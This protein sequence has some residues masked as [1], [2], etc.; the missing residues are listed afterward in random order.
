MVPSISFFQT[1]SAGT[2]IK[3][4]QQTGQIREFFTGSLLL[5]LMELTAFLM[6]FPVLALFSVELTLLVFV[7]AVLMGINVWITARAHRERL[8]KL[9]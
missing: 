9:Y 5:T 4:M 2:L 3:H 6:L 8:R 1:S 7:F